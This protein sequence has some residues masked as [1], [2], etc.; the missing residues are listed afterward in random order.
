VT[1]FCIG[2]EGL[3][4]A[5]EDE[6]MRFVMSCETGEESFSALCQQPPSGTWSNKSVTMSELHIADPPSEEGR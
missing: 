1:G 2:T 4:D 6:R 3:A 5:V